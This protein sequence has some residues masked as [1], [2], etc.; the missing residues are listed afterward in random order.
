MRHPPHRG[1]TVRYGLVS[2]DQS[3]TSEPV[4]LVATRREDGVIEVMI[5]ATF[6]RNSSDPAVDE[7]TLSFS[8]SEWLRELQM[9]YI[10]DRCW[11][12]FDLHLTVE[13]TDWI[14]L[15]R[16]LETQMSGGRT[17]S[18]DPRE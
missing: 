7:L 4:E 8:D 10:A 15:R 18:S 12:A 3:P 11:G 6:Y 5:R 1:I 2:G 14:P 13:E 9:E 17:V 16:E